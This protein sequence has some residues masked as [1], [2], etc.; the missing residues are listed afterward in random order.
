MLL[1]VMKGLQWPSPQI[2]LPIH[3]V[4]LQ[5][6]KHFISRPQDKHPHRHGAGGMHLQHECGWENNIAATTATA[7]AITAA[8]AD[9]AAE[10][11]WLHAQQRYVRGIRLP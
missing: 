2:L 5:I 10:A 7:A 11:R 1:D 9:A 4:L 3:Q 6:H 8:A